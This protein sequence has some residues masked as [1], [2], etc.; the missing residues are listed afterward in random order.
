MLLYHGTS[1]KFLKSIL[2][3]GLKPQEE[4][5]IFNYPAE[6]V[7]PDRVYLGNIT[8]AC[9]F[10][11]VSIKKYGGEVIILEL[12]LEGTDIVSDIGAFTYAYIGTIPISA[13]RRIWRDNSYL[14]EVESIENLE[15]FIN[16]VQNQSSRMIAEAEYFASL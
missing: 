16:N 12:E 7:E 2:N 3:E 15:E 11:N 1:S 10:G 14:Y 9:I 4:T 13:I 5:G 8:H 6:H